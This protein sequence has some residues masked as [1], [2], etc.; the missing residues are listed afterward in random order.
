[1]TN[2][3]DI[4]TKLFFLTKN[5]LFTARKKKSYGKKKLFCPDILEKFLGI[6][7]TFL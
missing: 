1:M 3:F 5:F 4:V 6:K 7:T 2:F